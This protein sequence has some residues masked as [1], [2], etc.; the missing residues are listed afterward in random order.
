[1]GKGSVKVIEVKNLTKKYG[2]QM[3]ID[4]LNFTIEDGRIYGFL[5]PNGAG[6]STTMNIMTGCLAATEGSVT[7]DSLDIFKDAQK[8]KKRIGYLPEHPPLYLEMTADEYLHFIAEAKGVEKKLQAG[9]VT[10]VEKKTQIWSV[11]NRLLNNLSKGYRQRVGIAQALLGNPQTII[12]DEPTNGLDP[13]QMMEIRDMIRELGKE[14]TVFISS[15][16]LSEIKEV[17]DHIL[18][19]SQGRLA[20]NDTPENLENLISGRAK[21]KLIVKASRE[22]AEAL[23]QSLDEEIKYILSPENGAELSISLSYPNSIDISEKIFSLFSKAGKP[24]LEMYKEKTNL[25]DVFLELTEESAEADEEA[26]A[27]ESDL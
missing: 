14:H 8:A 12:L 24:I 19:I 20:A 5:G 17:S 16:I 27:D 9:E 3:A 23:L 4:H 15:H 11:R 13:R 21:M 22:E 18:I 25:E 6:K 1:M 7:I 10:A 2:E 26:A